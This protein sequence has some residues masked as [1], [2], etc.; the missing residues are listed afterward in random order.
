MT[1][2]QLEHRDRVVIRF[3]G[4]SGDGM[5]ITGSQ[6]TNTAA[7]LGNDLATF[8]DYP[9]EIR[10]PAG[11]LPGVSGFQVH[12]A[13]DDIFTPGDAPDVLI[14]MNPAF[15]SMVIRGRSS[16]PAGYRLR[17]PSGAE[18]VQVA[19]AHPGTASRVSTPPDPDFHIHTVQRGQT[20]AGIAKR[21]RTSVRTLQGLNGVRS[22]RSL[23]VGQKLKVPTG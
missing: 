13:S 4:D 2:K 12:F 22:P 16:I 3:A 19:L 11:T 18:D 14:A 15:L 21:Y 9:A 17:V 10:A 8:P 23:R 7:L 1:T 5:Q 20:L 6:F